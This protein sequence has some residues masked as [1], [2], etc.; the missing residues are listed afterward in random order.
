M[1]KYKKIKDILT[2]IAI[3]LGIIGT[4]I[5]WIG[6]PMIEYILSNSITIKDIN[7]KIKSLEYQNRI[8][9][10]QKGLIT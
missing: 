1:N 7:N 2:L 6:G 8:N 9:E 5:K 4:L 3:I 10:K